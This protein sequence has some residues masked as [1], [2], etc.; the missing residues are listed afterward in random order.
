MK[1]GGQGRDVA[2]GNWDGLS[3]QKGNSLGSE[4]V[5]NLSSLITFVVNFFLF[6]S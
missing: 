6:S 3:C 5:A 2:H 4:K 1:I